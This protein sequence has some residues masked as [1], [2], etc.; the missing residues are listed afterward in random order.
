MPA[1]YTAAAKAILVRCLRPASWAFGNATLLPRGNAAILLATAVVY[2]A[3][4]GMP[5]ILAAFGGL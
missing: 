5:L 2:G 4:L 3:L 1:P